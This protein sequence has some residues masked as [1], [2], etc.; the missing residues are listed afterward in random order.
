MAIVVECK[1]NPQFPM[2]MSQ[3]LEMCIT[4][5]LDELT[6][7]NPYLS[8]P[9][10]EINQVG[11]SDVYE[12]ALLIHASSTTGEPTNDEQKQ[13]HQNAQ[14]VVRSDFDS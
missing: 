3:Y 5:Y 12:I 8:A 1:P 9:Y 4:K 7:V 6:F 13:I 14:D 10:L 11:E 2:S